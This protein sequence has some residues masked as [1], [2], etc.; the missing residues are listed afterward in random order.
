M[1]RLALPPSIGRSCIWLK[2]LHG[3]IYRTFLRAGDMCTRQ[4]RK[5]GR[6]VRRRDLPWA[7][8]EIIEIPRDTVDFSVEWK[9]FIRQRNDRT[10]INTCLRGK[11]G[12]FIIGV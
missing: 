7:Y 11:G 12:R 1:Y 10:I 2:S 9:S 4:R 6:E 8:G 5:N 3:Q